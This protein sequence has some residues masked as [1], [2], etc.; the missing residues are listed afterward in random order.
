MHSGP[1]EASKKSLTSLVSVLVRV[2]LSCV[3]VCVGAGNSFLGG[4]AAGLFLTKGDVYEGD[5]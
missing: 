2:A 5:S 3:H 4:L 1:P